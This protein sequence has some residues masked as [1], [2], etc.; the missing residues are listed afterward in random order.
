MTSVTFLINSQEPHVSNY[1]INKLPTRDKSSRFSLKYFTLKKN[2][3]LLNQRHSHQS[4]RLSSKRLT[5]TTVMTSG[6]GYSQEKESCLFCFPNQ[7]FWTSFYWERLFYLRGMIRKT[8]WKLA[9]NLQGFLWIPSEGFPGSWS[10]DNKITFL[11]W[12]EIFFEKNLQRQASYRSYPSN[13]KS[14]A[15]GVPFASFGHL[16]P[17]FAHQT[18]LHTLGRVHRRPNKPRQLSRE[19]SWQTMTSR[20]LKAFYYWKT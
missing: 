16:L 17:W 20:A 8:S 6:Y 13:L 18:A 9:Q 4:S 11:G 3:W 2:F 10:A 12:Q 1:L 5:S 19:T 15:S 14:T 7:S